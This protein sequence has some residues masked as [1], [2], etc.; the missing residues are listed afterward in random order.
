MMRFAFDLYTF[1]PEPFDDL[2]SN[3][4]EFFPGQLET[5]KVKILTEALD[6]MQDSEIGASN[7]TQPGCIFAEKI[8]SSILYWKYSFSMYSKWEGFL[9]SLS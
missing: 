3:L 9:R 7:K 8:L 6:M 1:L 4:I 2:V 5:I